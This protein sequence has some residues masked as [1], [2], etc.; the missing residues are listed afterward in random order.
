MSSKQTA[1]T[2]ILKE[3]FDQGPHCLIWNTHWILLVLYV[4]YIVFCSK[5]LNLSTMDLSSLIAGRILMRFLT[6]CRR[7]TQVWLKTS[8]AT[9]AIQMVKLRRN[10]WHRNIN[11]M[12][13]RMSA[14]GRVQR[15]A[16]EMNDRL[17]YFAHQPVDISAVWW[18]QMTHCSR[19]TKSVIRYCE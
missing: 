6:T 10:G 4:L 17:L 16:R 2:K 18:L 8:S 19:S 9:R 12:S 11:L 7:L 13:E 14:S 15:F 5:N 3:P 1:N